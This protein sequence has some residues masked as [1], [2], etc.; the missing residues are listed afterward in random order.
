MKNQTPVVLILVFMALVVMLSQTN[1]V[2]ATLEVLAW[3]IVAFGVGGIYWTIINRV[4]IA[5]TQRT[6]RKGR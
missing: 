3:S 1:N 5:R 2:L 4:E 6:N